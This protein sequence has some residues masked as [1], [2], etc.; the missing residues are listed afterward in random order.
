MIEIDKNAN[1]THIFIDMDKIWISAG[2]QLK[3]SVRKIS[4][5]ET[6]TISLTNFSFTREAP[7]SR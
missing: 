6:S 5:E 3:Q 7:V 4:R 2:E 1:E